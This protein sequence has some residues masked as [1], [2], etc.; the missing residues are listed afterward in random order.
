MNKWYRTRRSY[1]AYLN[2]Y[3]VN[4][5]SSEYKFVMKLF[6][7]CDFSSTQRQK[8]NHLES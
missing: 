8:S 6:I 3:K 2:K 4:V 5:Y 7:A 1:L